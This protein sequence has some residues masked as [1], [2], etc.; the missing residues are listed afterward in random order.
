VFAASHIYAN[1]STAMASANVLD[2]RGT[3][4]V[5]ALVALSTQISR[6]QPLQLQQ[7]CSSGSG[8]VS[9]QEKLNVGGVTKM[10]QH[11]YYT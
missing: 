5:G 3:A 2:I 8:G 1:V 10:L 9:T 11:S 6:L 4:N 7:R